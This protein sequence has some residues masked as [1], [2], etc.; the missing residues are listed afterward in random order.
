MYGKMLT[1]YITE[2]ARPLSI[3]ANFFVTHSLT[4]MSP[5]ALYQTL[6]NIGGI[7]LPIICSHAQS[8]TAAMLA[9]SPVIL[10]LSSASVK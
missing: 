6:A 1:P 3:L 7:C 8:S 9:G 5:R 10:S 2:Y 4:D